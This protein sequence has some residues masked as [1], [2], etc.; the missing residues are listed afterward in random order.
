VDYLVS[1]GIGRLDDTYVLHLKLMGI[2]QAVVKNRVSESCRGPQAQLA[3]AV[4]HGAAQ[5]LGRKEVG[6]GGITV[7][8]D[9]DGA[10]LVVDGQNPLVPPLK[11]P[12][13]DLS[14]GKHTISVSAEGFFALH[15]DVYIQPAQRTP[16]RAALEARPAAWY[17]KWWVWSAVGVAI[18]GAVSGSIILAPKTPDS[19]EVAV[20]IVRG[21]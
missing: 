8:S 4:W 12:I 11:Q 13:A 1:G 7:H 10:K 20:T 2:D 6:M 5:L 19:G 17:K 18:L 9:L 21:P 3:N 15:R 14:A 16:V